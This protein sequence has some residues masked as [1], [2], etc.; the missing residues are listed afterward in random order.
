MKMIQYIQRIPEYP[1]EDCQSDSNSRSNKSRQQ[2]SKKLKEVSNHVDAIS[3]K[4]G[5]FE[6][7]LVGIGNLADNISK[8]L[9]SLNTEHK[10]GIS[11]LRNTVEKGSKA[12]EE[13]VHQ[14]QNEMKNLKKSHEESSNNLKIELKQE[15]K[16]LN[17]SAS[18][19]KCIKNSQNSM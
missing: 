8:D 5:G 10:S 2:I 1:T 17:T 6:G 11:T 9:S 12:I 13:K 15:Q 19:N 14:V 16:L 3:E 7:R 4:V 18:Q